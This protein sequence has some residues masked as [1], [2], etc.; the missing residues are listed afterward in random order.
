MGRN[1]INEDEKKGHIS[2]SLSNRVLKYLR[3]KQNKSKYVEELIKKD[4]KEKNL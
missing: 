4:I 1:R 3:T 2:L